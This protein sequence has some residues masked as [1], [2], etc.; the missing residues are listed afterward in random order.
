MPT[1]MEPRKFAHIATLA[2]YATEYAN[3]LRQQRYLKRS[4][5]QHGERGVEQLY[6]PQPQLVNGAIVPAGVTAS[7]AKP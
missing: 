6:S 4:T 3:G 7:S 1:G 5:H 2:A